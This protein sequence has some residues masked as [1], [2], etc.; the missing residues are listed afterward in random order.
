MPK[1]PVGRTI[2]AA[3]SFAFRHFFAVLAIIWFPYV[4]LVAILTVPA[5]AMAPGLVH[6]LENQA[7]KPS[8]VPGFVGLG[9]LLWLGLL[10]AGAMVRVGLLRKALGLT[11]GRVFLYFSFATPVWRM[12]G[13]M[14]LASLILI[15]IGAASAGVAGV[16]WGVARALASN[17][18]AALLGGIAAFVALCW[19]IYAA[20]RLTFFLP[21]VV[22][23]E[24][25][26]GLGRAWALGRGNFWR[27]VIVAIAC[28]VPVAIGFAILGAFT[29][30]FLVPAT[31]TTI[32]S[33][34]DA[35]GLMQERWATVGPWSALLDLV[36]VT[37]IAG[38]WTGAI[39]GA[40]RAINPP[41]A[42]SA[43]S[44]PAETAQA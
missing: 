35:I 20:V 14:I 31:T 19:W 25:D 26:I 33:V 6:A 39:A 34:H 22:V 30:A 3:Y 17:Q 1:L 44:G 15:G 18:A 9:L 40:Y 38:L 8:L 10:V 11:H 24:E 16:I 4:V 37:L 2:E 13:A 21:A 7:F 42:D 12:L 23:A 41:E 27:I 29:G 28:F 5:I 32:M 43:Q 36:Y